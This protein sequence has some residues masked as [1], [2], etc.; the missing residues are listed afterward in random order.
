ML[1]NDNILSIPRYSIMIADHPSST[2]R[3]EVC[4]FYEEHLSII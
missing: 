4:L 3:G 2:K 1:I